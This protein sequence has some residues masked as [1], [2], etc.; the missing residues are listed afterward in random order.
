MK[1]DG[2]F[3]NGTVF[4]PYVCCGDPS[5]EFTLRLV[6]TL[7]ANGADAIELGIPFSDPIADGKIIQA[8]SSRSLAN[9]MTPKK[10]I[11]M[12]TKLRT[13]NIKV[14]IFVMTYYNIVYSNGIEKFVKEIQ[15]AGAN[16]L[17]VPDVTLDESGE[18]EGICKKHGIDLI[19][20][21]TPNTPPERLKKITKKANG[22]L[23]AV[24]VLGTTGTREQNAPEAIEL[25][26]RAKQITA[27]PIVAGFG[28]SNEKQAAEFA[29]AG[30][31]GII[32]GSRL[33]EIYSNQSDMEGKLREVAKFT[34]RIKKAIR[35][36]G[37]D[38]T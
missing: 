33:I 9:G 15:I 20:F 13:Q 25:V 24:S 3:G 12:I 32:I 37:R 16:G 18:L 31:S 10:A 35:S 14:P 4:M 28:I 22:F 19:Y 29:D 2:L 17:I 7:V 6:Q 11:G 21:I 1:L 8:A 26:K 23:Y 30:A 5:E 27:I 38:D 36:G 34:D